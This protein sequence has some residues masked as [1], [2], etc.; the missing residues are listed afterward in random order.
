[1]RF[2]VGS[3]LGAYELRSLIGAGGMGEVY[4]GRDTRIARDVAIKV[5]L[6]AAGADSS[7]RLRLNREAR[8][9]SS[10]N[11][12]HIC[13][14]YDV[15]S[16]NGADYLVMELIEGESLATRL[17]RGP[18]P[19]KRAICTR[20]FVTRSTRL[21]WRPSGMPFGTRTPGGSK[22]TFPTTTPNSG[23]M[24]ATTERGSIR[25]CSPTR[26]SR[27]TTD[28]AACQNVPP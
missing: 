1:M 13:A 8:A 24:C 19:A 6:E 7:S 17:A 10:L 3:R 28:C 20:S 23:C 12:P 25:R 11:H 21:Q 4:R 5:L 14:L 18:L 16:E 9:L 2:A 22:S 27:A 15:G 26:G